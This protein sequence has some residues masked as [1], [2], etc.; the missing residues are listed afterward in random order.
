MNLLSPIVICVIPPIASLACIVLLVRDFKIKFG[1]ISLLLGL[2]AVLPI[3][4]IQFFIELAFHMEARSLP[5]IMFRDILI[6]G[7]VEETIKMLFLFFLSSR[8]LSL[9]GFFACSI[10]S[11]ISLGCFETLIYF[12]SGVQKSIELRL[13]TAVIIHACCTGLAGLFVYSIK[14]KCTRLYP[15]VL[16]VCLHGI[17]NYFAGFR[18]TSFFF[19]FSILVVLVALVECRVRYRSFVPEKKDESMALKNTR[20]NRK[21]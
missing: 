7:F 11:G 8:K 1:I 10:L 21:S 6:N 4:A 14:T 12:I 16:S 5:S 9:E 3:A 19:Y 2:F 17:Y 20:E 13:L 18:M 15:Y